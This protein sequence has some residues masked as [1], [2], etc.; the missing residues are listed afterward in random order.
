MAS[1]KK[2]QGAYKVNTSLYRVENRLNTGIGRGFLYAG[3]KEEAKKAG[4]NNFSKGKNK[5]NA[6]A[7]KMTEVKF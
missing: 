5:L 6:S 1:L 2:L 7:I 3:S 4:I